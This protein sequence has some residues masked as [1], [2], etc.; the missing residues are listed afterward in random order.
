MSIKLLNSQFK[1]NIFYSISAQLVSLSVAFIVNLVVP[2]FIDTTNY[3][4]WQTFVLY[5]GYVGI[6]HFGLLDGLMLRYSQYNYEDI[7]K[8][9]LSSQFKI[10]LCILTV[11][12]SAGLLFSHFISNEI[13]SRVVLLVS[14][15]ILSKNFFTYVSYSFQ[16]TNRIHLY[17]RLIVL[18]RVIY[19]L[20]ITLF[21]VFGYRNFYLICIAE[22]ASEIFSSIICSAWN[23]G[24]YFS[25]SEDIYRAFSEF[26]LNISSGIALL[27]A[28]WASML[29]IGSA[30]MIIQWRWNVETFALFSFAISVTNL[31]FTF[32]TSI[33]IVLFP[34]LKRLDTKELPRL[35][36]KLRVILSVFLLWC[37]IL[38]YPISYIL[39]LWL[40]TYI[41]SLKYLGLILPIIV[42]TSKVTLL[43]NNYL[44]TYRKESQIL[45]INGISLIVALFGFIIGA[46]ILNEV[47][48]VIIA[49][50]IATIFRS[51]ISEYEVSKIFNSFRVEDFLMEILLTIV[52]LISTQ[53]M[54][55]SKGFALYAIVLLPYSIY[56][57]KNKF[58]SIR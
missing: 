25:K 46:Y 2:K 30:R 41:M 47:I 57:L 40:P 43:T 17:T 50:L 38:Y 52:F 29:L 39:G 53:T 45:K 55:L 13:K 16:L 31:F 24:M 8:A 56:V 36:L 10:L 27:V 49:M 12:A 6:L 21:L 4:Y 37:M 5:S 18:H 9:K 23:R 42:Y 14:M 35:Y 11:C 32:I 34:S 3:G 33:S 22:I 19:L 51:I 48:L 58:S 28:N 1:K 44:K 7:D 54:S 15:S 26:R 20:L